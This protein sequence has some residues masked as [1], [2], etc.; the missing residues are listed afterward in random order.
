MSSKSFLLGASLIAGTL[1]LSMGLSQSGLAQEK[2]SPKPP[3]PR[4]DLAFCIDT[5]GSMQHEIDAVKTKTKEIVAKLAGSKPAPEIRVG[6]VAFRDRGD[7]YVTKVFQFSDDID[8]VVKDISSL[9]A[10]GGGDTPEAVNEALHA[11]VHDLKWTTDKKAVKLLF[12]IGD[13]GPHVYPGDYSWETESRSAISRGIQINTIACDGLN[14]SGDGL[15]VFQK[16]A[17]LS[18]G[19]CEFLTYKQDI[20]DAGGHKSTY[21]SS[22]GKMFK[23]DSKRADWHEGADRLMAKG[24]AEDLSVAAG[25]SGGGASGFA[26]AAAAPSAMFDGPALSRAKMSRSMLMAPS[27]RP[28]AASMPTSR[29]ESNLADIVLKATK[30]AA[31]KKANIEYKD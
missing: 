27:A 19:K 5:T 3:K 22:A 15:D 29:S 23:V 28:M 24:A 20:V 14:N 2:A 10:D 16:I 1:L 26:T 31:K 4:I 6:V 18:D 25:A 8:K 21:V 7:A 30:D 9:E 13:A 12:L 17:K 11:S